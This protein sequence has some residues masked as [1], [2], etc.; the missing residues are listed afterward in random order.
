MLEVRNVGPMRVAKIGYII[1]SVLFCIFGV[2]LMIVPHTSIAVIASAIGI[3]MILFGIIKLIGYFSKDL[4]RLAFQY[5]LA[6]GIL[7][8]TL[9]VI[10]LLEPA[11]VIEFICVLL[12]IAVLTDGLYKIQISIDAKSFGIKL[13]WLIMIEAIST[14]II[15]VLLIMMPSNASK[16]LTI[17]IGIS[18]LIVGLLNLSTVLTAVKIIKHQK[19]DHI[20]EIYEKDRKD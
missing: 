3:G 12:G 20:D 5:D 7:L 19:N 2:V 16:V 4:Y 1:M 10:V 13:W 11:K 8:I 18:S 17:L 6:F 14:S 9:G 15:G